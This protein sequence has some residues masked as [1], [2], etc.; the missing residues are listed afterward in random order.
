MI[1][2]LSLLVLSNWCQYVAG[3]AIPLLQQLTDSARYNQRLT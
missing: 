2:R 3:T 1:E